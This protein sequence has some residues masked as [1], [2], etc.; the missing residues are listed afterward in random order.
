MQTIGFDRLYLEDFNIGQLFAT[1]Q[2]WKSGNVYATQ[3]TRKTS[4]LLYLKD[5]RAVYETGDGIKEYRSGSVLYLPQNSVYKTT[6]FGDNQE[7][8]ITRLVEFELRDM[9]GKPFACGDK[10]MLVDTD[11]SGC[12]CELFDQLVGIYKSFVYSYG[13]FK[14]V[15]YALISRI[16]KLYQKERI[17]SPKFRAIAPALDYLT[18]EPCT[19]DTVADLARMCHISETGF[20]TLFKEFSGKTPAEYC[21]EQKMRRARKLLQTN[22]YSVAEVAE[23]LGYTDPGYFCKVFKKEN[24]ISPK[25][26]SMQEKGVVK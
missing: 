25:A 22:L 26:F 9:E 8:G 14:S 4:A 18:R 15:L 19:H 6:F 10:V 23:L 7:Y 11:S 21:L 2:Q 16:A 20:R 1:N 24:G 5:C 13:E 17:Y 12:Y 3:R